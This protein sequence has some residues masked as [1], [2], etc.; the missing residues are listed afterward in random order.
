MKKKILIL[1]SNGM[2]GSSITRYLSD[3]NYVYAC[4]RDKKN[5]TLFERNV[6]SG[7]IN[8]VD[9]LDLKNIENIITEISP[10]IV[11]NCVGIIKQLKES[12][13]YEDSIAINSLYPH[14]LARVCDKYQA[15]LIHFSTDCVFSGNKG[16]YKE[17]DTPDAIDL[18]GR[19]KLLGEVNYGKHLTIR[20]SIIGHE[21]KSPVSLVD[22]FLQQKEVNGFSKAIFSGLPTIFVAHI[23]EELIIDNENVKGLLNL[24][25][26]PINKYE[27]LKLI[28]TQYGS[29]CKIN[30]DKLFEIDRSLN[31]DEFT[32]VTGY[33]PP[34]W[35][36]L[37]KLMHE[38]YK[39]YFKDFR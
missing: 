30:E 39:K 5:E 2:L 37:I 17:S 31:H 11:I 8:N 21:N 3:N 34:D 35:K 26:N 20:T 10:N 19:S 29:T 24:S 16:N 18:Y 36:D 6:L 22:W 28:D 15:K 13:Q 23:L 38:E 7:L 4:I 27:L 14:Q 12:K 33:T 9:V 25:T 1:G 32:S